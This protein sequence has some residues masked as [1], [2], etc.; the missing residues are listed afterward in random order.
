MNQD[1]IDADNQQTPKP[2]IIDILG[3]Q[4]LRNG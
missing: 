3:G 2:N 1:E 4:A